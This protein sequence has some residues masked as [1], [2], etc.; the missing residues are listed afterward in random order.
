[1]ET[2]SIRVIILISTLLL[3]ALIQPGVAA[4]N[5]VVEPVANPDQIAALPVDPVP[6]SFWSLSPREMAIFLALMISPLLLFPVELLFSLRL[7]SF[8]GYRK[9]EQNAILYNENRRIIFEA[10]Q[11]NPGI[12]FIDLCR[13]TG[14]NRGTVKYHLVLL[15]LSRKISTVSG[16]GSDRYFENNGYYSD[17]ERL[18]FQ[19]LREETTRKIIRIVLEKPDITQTEVVEHVGISAPSVSRHMATLIREGIVTMQKTGRQVRYRISEAA[20]PVLREYWDRV[21]L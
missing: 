5:Y 17:I 14:I 10:V 21:V 9:I 6:V 13:I 12:I 2:R 16:E 20:D 7:F 19:H 18:L 11:S 1:M 3:S 4:T 15:Q 8:L